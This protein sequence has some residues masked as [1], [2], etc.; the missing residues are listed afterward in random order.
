[1]KMS[2]LFQLT[3]LKTKIENTKMSIKTTYKFTRLFKEAEEHINFFN[4]TL[5]DLIKEYGQKDE[6]GNFVLT[7]N[8]NGVKIREDK[9]DECM[10]KVQELNELDPEL[11]YI[12]SF[13]LEELDNLEL[14]IEELNTLMPFIEEE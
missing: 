1:M 3:Q 8:Q 12:P 10:K 14:S 13:T 7:E 9:Y 5:A 6:E 11:T 2:E 4:N